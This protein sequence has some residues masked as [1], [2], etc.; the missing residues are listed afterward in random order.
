MTHVYRRRVMR[1]LYRKT[2]DGSIQEDRLMTGLYRK[3]PV[4][5]AMTGVYRENLDKG[6]SIQGDLLHSHDGCIQKELCAPT[7]GVYTG[8][9]C[10]PTL[11]QP[12]CYPTSGVY[13]GEP[14]IPH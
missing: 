14:E 7:S 12:S 8:G 6:G 10:N 11:R 4:S 3:N 2:N 9:T 1:G 5:T 13:T